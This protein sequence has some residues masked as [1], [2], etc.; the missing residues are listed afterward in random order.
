M[1]FIVMIEAERCKGCELCVAVCPQK[2][3][4][5]SSSISHHGTH[6]SE[7]V[8]Q[9][10]CTGCLRC[11]RICPDAAIEVATDKES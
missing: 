7:V 5:M 1:R 6:I 9:E 11:A 3:L 4:A 10:D 2:V 8:A